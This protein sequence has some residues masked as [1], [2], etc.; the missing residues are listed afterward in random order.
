MSGS[1]GKSAMGGATSGSAGKLAMGGATSGSAGKPAM[2]GSGG[3]AEGGGAGQGGA[4][5][6]GAGCVSG[7]AMFDKGCEDA[8]DCSFGLHQVDAC[9]MDAVAFN[10][11]LAEAFKL[12]EAAWQICNPVV[13]CSTVSRTTTDK[14]DLM[15]SEGISVDCKNNV[16]ETS[17]N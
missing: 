12:A 6:G 16:C 17:P 8:S 9:T 3:K 14:G 4:G 2:G 1:A 11:A 15:P 5:Q 10:H 13:P 7:F